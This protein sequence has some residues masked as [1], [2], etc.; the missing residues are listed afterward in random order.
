MAF[1]SACD[2]RPAPHAPRGPA[3]RPDAFGPSAK[4]TLRS[5]GRLDAALTRPAATDARRA[6]CEAVA[7]TAA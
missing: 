5:R 2:I 4:D 7:R 1:A 6:P 3:C